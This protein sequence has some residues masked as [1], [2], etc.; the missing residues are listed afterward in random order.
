MVR[1]VGQPIKMLAEAGA[2]L[3]L[4]TVTMKA[5]LSYW[6]SILREAERELEAATTRAVVGAAA[7]K[8]M[9]AKAQVKR[10]QAT[11]K[12]PVEAS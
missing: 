10:L 12:P 3:Y 6:T 5:N 7:K 9:D 2:A 1:D 8:L 4:W 11:K